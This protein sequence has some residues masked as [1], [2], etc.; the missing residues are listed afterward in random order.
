MSE[1]IKENWTG[2]ISRRSF[3]GGV[4]TVLLSD[5]STFAQ[6]SAPIR[7]GVLN[8]QSGLLADLAGVGSVEAARMAVE[9]RGGSVLGRKIEVL[10]ADHQ[11]K[12]DVGASIIRKWID[13]DGVEAVFDLGNSAISL[14]AQEIGRERGKIIVHTTPASTELTG[15]ACSPFGFH[16]VYDNYSNGAGL[17][18]ALTLGGQDTWFF[19][20]VDYAFG[21]SLESEARTAIEAAGGR[22]LDSIRHPP[23]T[24]DFSSYLLRAQA[25]KAKVIMFANVGQD[26]TNSLKQAAEFGIGQG[27]TSG[28]TLAAPVVLLTDVHAMGLKLAQGLKFI[29]GFY[30]DLDESTRKW[31]NRFFEKRKAMPTMAQAGT[32]SAVLHYLKSVEAAQSI[33]GTAVANAMRA[34]PANDMFARNGILR[35]DGRMVHDMLLVEVKSPGESRYAWDYYKVLKVVPGSDAFRPLAQ[36]SCPSIKT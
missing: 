6:T 19:I 17:A 27:P 36:S 1:N 9:E 21:K 24:S 14:A 28:Q 29:T 11:N 26:L 25:S 3:M 10:S 2:N 23:N 34:M 32:Y 35:P 30:W 8:D 33:D 22:V 5:R 18:K 31:S 13:S 15:R 20:T 16:W 7:I 12:P 4:A